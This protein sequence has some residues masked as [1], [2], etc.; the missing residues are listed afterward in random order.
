MFGIAYSVMSL[1]FFLSSPFWGKMTTLINSKNAMAFGT[2][3]YGIAQIFFT[4][5]QIVPLIL[6]GRFMAGLSIGAVLVGTLTYI[7]DAAPAKER[8]G[9]FAVN[10]T[11]QTVLRAAGYVFGGILGQFEMHAVFIT[12][13]VLLILLGIA[14][15][16]LLD[17]DLNHEEAT[18]KEIAKD[19]NPLKA[20][21]DGKNFM[22]ASFVVL[23]LV[24]TFVFLGYTAFDQ[25]L[26]FYMRDMLHLPSGYNGV[27]KGIVA[28]VS[29][30]A[31]LTICAYIL[32]KTQIKKSVIVVL[33]F[34]TAFLISTL[35]VAY[36]PA[37]FV[38]NLIVF[39]GYAVVVPLIQDMI[40]KQATDEN[41]N[42]VLGFYQS[43]ESLGM[44]FGSFFAGLL[45]KMQPKSPFVFASCFFVLALLGSIYFYKLMAKR[46]AKTQMPK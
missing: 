24:S 13:I 39:G 46:Q 28:L 17:D 4:F 34:T 26:N 23:F 15:Y 36:L 3:T 43:T 21:M 33:F 25:S 2:V 12:Q 18:W 38:L 32:K 29:L 45:Y 42:M 41:R 31:N 30:V 20:F 1:G 19:S 11:V 9:Y 10:V 7:A 5:G 37:F 8:G 27:F 16:Y 40:A 44:I 22:N 35:F 14:Y 6:F